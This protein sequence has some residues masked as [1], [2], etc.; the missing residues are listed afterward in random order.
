MSA[1][2]FVCAVHVQETKGLSNHDMIMKLQNR[3]NIYE[4]LPQF[5]LP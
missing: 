1:W 3:D 2:G 5:H 4:S